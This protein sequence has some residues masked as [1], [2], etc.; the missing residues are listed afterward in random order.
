MSEHNQKYSSHLFTLRL[1]QEELGDERHEWRGKIQ[2][3]QSGE[4]YYFRE[5][6]VLMTAIS[7][8]IADRETHP[9]IG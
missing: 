5:W 7:K 4:T 6:S 2:H 9:E 1:W 3:V 8:M